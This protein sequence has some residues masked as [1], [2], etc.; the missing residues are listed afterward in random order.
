MVG[1][2]DQ[3]QAV[4]SG[5]HR[6]RRH[7]R[8]RIAGQWLEHDR[9]GLAAQGAELL[10]DQKTMLVVADEQRGAEQRRVGDALHGFLQQ[11]FLPDQGHQ[12]LRIGGA[13]ERPE[14]RA[15]TAGQD[16][17]T[18][19]HDRNDSRKAL[20]TGIGSSTQ[21]TSYLDRLQR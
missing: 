20:E 2:Q 17:G 1:G 10:G 4:G 13:G 15:G 12:L 11:A 14:P 16:D 3:Q 18:D 19:V 9:L 6:R 21:A 5:H 7:R 8:G